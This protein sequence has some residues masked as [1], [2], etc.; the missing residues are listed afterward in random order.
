MYLQAGGGSAIY[1]LV[2]KLSSRRNILYPL[3]K[4]EMMNMSDDE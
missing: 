2:S 4:C 3:S 1:L